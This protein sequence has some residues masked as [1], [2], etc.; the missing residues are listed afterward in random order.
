MNKRICGMLG[1]LAMTLT[2]AWGQSSEP[3][4]KAL[5]EEKLGP[6]PKSIEDI[7]Y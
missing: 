3:V 6:I 4:D 1:L 2:V 7:V 5:L